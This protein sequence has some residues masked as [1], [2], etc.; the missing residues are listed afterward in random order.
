MSNP[1]NGIVYDTKFTVISLN[2]GTLTKI[3]P[4]T[5]SNVLIGTGQIGS[6]LGR[7]TKATGV[8]SLVFSS[9][10][11]ACAAIVAGQPVQV[12]CTVFFEGSLNELGIAKN[13]VTAA[14]ANGKMTVADLSGIYGARYLDFTITK[15]VGLDVGVPVS[16]LLDTAK[17][18]TNA[19]S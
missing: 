4:N 1:F 5:G 18:K 17:Y 12:G 19:R 7:W 14:P 16:L 10:A 15:V 8:S 9:V 6:I 13:Q 2:K 3:K 11:F